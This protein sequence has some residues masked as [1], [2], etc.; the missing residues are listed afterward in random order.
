[1]TF[2]AEKGL[3]P[4]AKKHAAADFLRMLD[5]N[6]DQFISGPEQIS[7]VRASLEALKDED[8]P[9]AKTVF[10]MHQQIYMQGPQDFADYLNLSMAEMIREAGLTLEEVK[11]IMPN[12]IEEITVE[13]VQDGISD[14]F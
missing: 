11:E 4:E 13:H 6:N 3:S 10:L 7:A 9:H 8:H 2:Y 5:A 12:D 1:M 14:L